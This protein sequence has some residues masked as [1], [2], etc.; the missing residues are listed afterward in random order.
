MAPCFV[1]NVPNLITGVADDTLMQF[2][3]YGIYALLG[4]NWSEDMKTIRKEFGLAVWGALRQLSGQTTG[5]QSLQYWVT[6]GVTD[7]FQEPADRQ[8][9]IAGDKQTAEIDVS[10]ISQIPMAFFV[11]LRDLACPQFQ[12]RKY[13]QQITAPTTW[14]DVEGEGHMYFSSQANSDWFMTNLI[15]Q[16]QVP[17]SDQALQ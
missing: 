1:A 15:E 13:I 14:I 4:P 9:F 8:E 17:T 11:G 10:K 7:R 16:L 12:A 3:D 2:Q 5:V 6:N